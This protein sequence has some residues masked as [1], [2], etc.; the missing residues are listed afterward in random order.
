MGLFPCADG[1]VAIIIVQPAH[2][3]AMAEW[4]HEVS[5]NEG[6]LDDIFIDMVMRREAS[7]AID[8]WVEDLTTRS[9]KRDLF[10]EGQR[11]GIP[12]TP[13][14]TV[15]DLRNDAHLAAI[16]WWRAEEHPELGSYMVPG[17]PFVTPD[18]WWAWR[19]APLLGEHT[20]EVLGALDG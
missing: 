6:V 1:F 5:G 8:L 17:S 19:R 3:T 20:D 4:M 13:V 12:I 9:T 11:R 14:N 15:A 16:G 18:D 10:M 2:W 7:E